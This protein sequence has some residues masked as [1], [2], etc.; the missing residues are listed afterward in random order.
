[1]TAKKLHVGPGTGIGAQ[2]S[3]GGMILPLQVAKKPEI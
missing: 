1:M 3:S 2:R